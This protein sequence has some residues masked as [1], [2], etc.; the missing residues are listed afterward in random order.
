MARINLLPWREELRKQ[1]LNDFLKSIGIFVV[2]TLV[3][4]LGV[5]MVIEGMKD[6]Q[7][8]RNKMLDKEIARL[9]ITIKEIKNIETK[10]NKMLGKIDVI[11]KLQ[12]SR[13]QIVHLFEDLAKTLPEGVYLNN[14]K[15]VKKAL[16]MEGLSQSNA[17]VSAYMRA[18]DAS[19]W[20]R[21]PQ[22]KVIKAGAGKGGHS[23]KFTMQAQQSRP[24]RKKQ[25]KPQVNKGRR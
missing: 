23:D 16:T 15:Q 13:P 7:N 21:S 14:V 9:N 22:L 4:L 17:R 2:F 25:A 8:R 18:I 20:L 5:H 1:Y 6:Y 11:H 3:V 19:Q 12:L 24:K 10:K